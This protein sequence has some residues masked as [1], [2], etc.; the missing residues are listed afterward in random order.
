MRGPRK[1]GPAP[2]LWHRGR[3][4]K[5][6]HHQSPLPLGVPGYHTSLHRPAQGRLVGCRLVS[7]NTYLQGCFPRGLDRQKLSDIPSSHFCPRNWL[8]SVKRPS[9]EHR[10]TPTSLSPGPCPCAQ[11]SDGHKAVEFSRATLAPRSS[12]Q[13]ARRAERKA[14]RS[15]MGDYGPQPHIS[16]I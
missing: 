1:W 3:K 7:L 14:L 10:V 6:L 12:R 8:R 5:E 11:E 4:V 2:S 13:L 9:E 15:N 16:N